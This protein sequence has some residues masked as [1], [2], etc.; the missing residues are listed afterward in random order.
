M[1]TRSSVIGKF[2]LTHYDTNNQTETT[3]TK[4]VY[5]LCVLSNPTQNYIDIGSV[6]TTSKIKGIKKKTET[7]STSF[8]LQNPLV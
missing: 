8:S 4:E 3:D 2:W 6:I 1:E 5:N 7:K